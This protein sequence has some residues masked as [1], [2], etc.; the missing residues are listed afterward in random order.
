M[1]QK[2]QRGTVLSLLLFISQFFLT[3]NLRNCLFD[4]L[5][6]KKER[7]NVSKSILERREDLC[8]NGSRNLTDIRLVC[9]QTSAVLEHANKLGHYL[10]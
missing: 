3:R 7:L 2:Q 8:M 10:L 6:R 9:T 4:S 1:N 5:R